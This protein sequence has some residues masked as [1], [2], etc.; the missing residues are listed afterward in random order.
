MKKGYLKQRNKLITYILK[1]NKNRGQKIIGKGVF[2]N[3]KSKYK[4]TNSTSCIIQTGRIQ[5]LV[6]KKQYSNQ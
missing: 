1:Q 4:K 6:Q 3:E 2:A 5:K